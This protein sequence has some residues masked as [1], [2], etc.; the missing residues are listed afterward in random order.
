MEVIKV[1][2]ANKITQILLM[3][4]TMPE[5]KTD[6]LRCAEYFRVPGK[7]NE[8]RFMRLYHLQVNS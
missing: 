3:S 5:R 2:R 8:C 4:D 6:I 7:I 1:P